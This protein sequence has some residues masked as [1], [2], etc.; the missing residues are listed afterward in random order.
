MIIPGLLTASTNKADHL[1]MSTDR[2]AC[3]S[4]IGAPFVSVVWWS[5][6][7]KTVFPPRR[8]VG[9]RVGARTRTRRGGTEWS[10]RRLCGELRGR[11]LV[12]QSARRG[13]TKSHC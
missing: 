2:V 3:L 5:L 1:G 7:L 4:M 13:E 6:V 10:T 12:A 8:D 11:A 9:T